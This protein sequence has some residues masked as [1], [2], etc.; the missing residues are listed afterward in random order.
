MRVII[1][2]LLLFVAGYYCYTEKSQK[3]LTVPDNFNLYRYVSQFVTI[4]HTSDY[5]QTYIF[6]TRTMQHLTS[7]TIYRTFF[8]YGD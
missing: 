5:K 4:L 2:K 6:V 3:V 8:K 7:H 1:Y